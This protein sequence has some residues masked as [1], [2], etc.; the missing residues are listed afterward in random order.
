MIARRIP[1]LLAAGLSLSAFT[2]LSWAPPKGFNYDEANVPPYTLPDPLVD[3]EGARVDAAKWEASR[4]AEVLDLFREHVYGVQP[5]P[6]EGMTW[7]VYEQSEEALGGKAIRKQVKLFVSGNDDGPVLDLLLYLPKN[8]PEPVPVFL[9]LNFGGNHTTHTDPAIT[10]N[11]GWMRKGNGIVD[12]RA[13]E[14]TRGKAFHRW[15]VEM[16]LERGF[17]VATMYCGDIDPDFDDGFENGVH[18]LYPDLQNRG[19]NFSTISAWA[20]GLSRA[21]DFLEKDDDIDHERVAVLGHSRLGKTAL[22]AGAT[23]ERF[24]MVISNNS[25][26]GGAALARRRFGETVERINTSFP[27][28]FCENHKKFNGN[29]DALPV[30]QHALIALIAPRLVYVASAS[31]DQWAD[32]HGEFLSAKEG[33]RVYELLWSEGIPEDAEWPAAGDHLHAEAVGYH[34]REGK[35][36][37]EEFDWDLFIGFA[38]SRI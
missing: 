15:P 29:E 33:S 4:R 36:D 11:A 7:D 22:W 23:D 12:H 24:A 13:T 35:H 10:F 16:I 32:P 9:G 26:C 2:G 6:P 18:A 28:W 34:L 5:P 3:A 27:H 21:M 1:K 14:A 37:V 30:D 17:G 20:W 25:G 19:D 8:A 31:E 38:E